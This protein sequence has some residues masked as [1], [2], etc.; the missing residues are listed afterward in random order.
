MSQYT[1]NGKKTP[2]SKPIWALCGHDKQLSHVFV[3]VFYG[4]DVVYS[5]RGERRGGL[6]LD[7]AEAKLQEHDLPMPAALK[8]SLLRDLKGQNPT[9][10]TGS[11]STEV[12]V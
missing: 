11:F 6:D 3:D 4:E 1:L 5:S 10:T 7:A 8:D 2:T 9:N 12:Q